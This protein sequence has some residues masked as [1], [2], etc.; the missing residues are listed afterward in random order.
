MLVPFQPHHNVI[1]CKWVY[2]IKQNPNGTITRHKAKLIAKGF[3]QRPE[4]D[5]QKT[6]NPVVKPATV[7]LILT[8]S[9]TLDWPMHQLNVNNAFLQG[10]LIED[11]YITQPLSFSHSE[12]P[13]YV[14]KLTRAMY[15]LRQAP[16]T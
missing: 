1:R 6:F 15:D 4:V 7:W 3:H 5:F 8:L 9:V 16:Q 2:R 13:N 11:V 12:H 14:Y 10:T